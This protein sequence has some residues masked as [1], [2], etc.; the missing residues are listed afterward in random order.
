MKKSVGKVLIILMLLLNTS[1]QKDRTETIEYN[2]DI[3]NVYENEIKLLFGEIKVI[4]KE[5]LSNTFHGYTLIKTINYDEWQI[6]YTNLNLEVK[7]TQF[8]NRDD[9]ISS[10]SEIIIEEITE[11][12]IEVLEL[13]LS[14]FI[15]YENAPENLNVIEDIAPEYYPVNLR[16]ENLPDDLLIVVTPP[17]NSVDD[18]KDSL[19][20]LVEKIKDANIKAMLLLEGNDAYEMDHGVLVVNGKVI[21]KKIS[22]IDAVEWIESNR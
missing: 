8:N 7:Q 9:F 11:E 16:F 18:F 20:K 6:E 12:V 1:C 5:R 3:L 10:M 17:E 19:I 22:V 15:N 13:E 14:L 2:K 4:S 21:H